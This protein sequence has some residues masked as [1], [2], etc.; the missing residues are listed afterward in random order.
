M[1]FITII[2]SDT[3]IIGNNKATMMTILVICQDSVIRQ[4]PEVSITFPFLQ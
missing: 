2:C 4:F 1:E 3:F